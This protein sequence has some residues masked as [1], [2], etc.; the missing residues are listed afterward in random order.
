M[1]FPPQH[2]SAGDIEKAPLPPAHL[3][4]DKPTTTLQEDIAAYGLEK[5]YAR[6]GRIDLIPL[7]SDDPHDPYNWSSWIKHVL[8]VQVAFHA[9]MGPF[10]AAA[11]IP[12]FETFVEDFGV[13][14]TQASYLVSVPIV[15]LG[16]FPL[17]WAPISNRIGRRPVLLISALFSAAMHFAG[18]YCH[19]YGT[20]MVTRVFQAIFLAPPQSLGAN[21]VNEM[22]FQHEKGQKLGIWT[23]LTSLGP[24][25]AP[26]IMGP[27]VW[28]T[29]KWQWTFYLLAIINLVQF[30]LYI[31]LAP[32][33][34]GFVRPNR[35]TPEA[36]AAAVSPKP[37]TP[38]WKLY[39]SFKRTSPAPWSQVPIETVRPFTMGLHLTVLLPAIAYSIAFAYT[40]VLL[41]VEIPAL[42][43]RKYGLNPQQIG[44]QFVGAV[45]GAIL[46]EIVAGTGS[47]WWMIWRTKRAGGNREPEM[48]LP[49]GLPGFILG[50]VGI[51]IFGV[52]LQNTAA[53]HWNVT[54]I[55][56]VAIAVFGT[57]IVT[58]VCYAY[59]IESVPK[60]I[61]YRV[62]PF[63]AFVRQLYAF[64]APFYLNIPFE[65][66]GYAKAAG[67]L[68]ALTGGVGFLVRSSFLLLRT[69]LSDAAEASSGLRCVPD[70][71]C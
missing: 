7:P 2:T 55:I 40:N 6:H 42:L 26:L 70:E 3:G 38:W 34:A 33:T 71:R 46:G 15:F 59:A 35:G 31:F 47:D 27:V 52:Q 36:D 25:V 54:P 60:A 5:V 50:A 22:F 53:G 21:M 11:V 65:E 61:Q 66:W 14:I 45:I 20:L 63:I 9:M 16:F 57:Q 67:L 24:P 29:G 62:S 28:N 41:T 17:L 51:L 1:A 23:L 68:C 18:A 30:I 69:T 32:E 56:G 8:L 13:S 58:T 44:L 37:K 12:S 10:S 49:F 43:G 64:T 48:R 39:F 19:S 4:E